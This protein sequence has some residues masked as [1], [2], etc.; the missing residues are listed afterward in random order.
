MNQLSHIPGGTGGAR[1]TIH[2]PPEADSFFSVFAFFSVFLG[3][4]GLFGLL[5]FFGLFGLSATAII[6]DIPARAFQLEA[7]LRND[8]FELPFTLGTFCERFVA[9]FLH[10]F[11][12]VPAFL[13]NVLIDGHFGFSSIITVKIDISI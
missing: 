8:L 6:A 1:E 7:C 12:F 2:A 5:A 4:F 9:H 11:Q 3:L 13:T 10:H